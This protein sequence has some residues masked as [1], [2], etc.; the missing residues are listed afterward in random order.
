MNDRFWRSTAHRDGGEEAQSAR[1]RE[2]SRALP[3]LI[4]AHPQTAPSLST[5]ATFISVRSLKPMLS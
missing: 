4:R 2:R 1:T 3:P 5:I